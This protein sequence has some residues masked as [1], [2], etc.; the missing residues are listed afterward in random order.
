MIVSP[1]EA[2]GLFQVKSFPLFHIILQFKAHAIMDFGLLV[3]QFPSIISCETNSG[4]F[5]MR[6]YS[7]GLIDL[8]VSTMK[9]SLICHFKFIS[10]FAQNRQI[11]ILLKS[12]LLR[13]CLIW[14]NNQSTSEV[15]CANSC[16]N[17]D[18]S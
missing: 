11:K 14:A 3:C 5:L 8:H 10:Y 15:S 4:T 18:C 16:S 13:S 9:L 12:N 2:M 1:F 17:V 7:G 6:G